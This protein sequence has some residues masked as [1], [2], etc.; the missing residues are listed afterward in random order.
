[1]ANALGWIDYCYLPICGQY[2]FSIFS[3]VKKGNMGLKWGND[4]KRVGLLFFADV[5]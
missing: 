4:L 2:L 5:C 3:G 1:M